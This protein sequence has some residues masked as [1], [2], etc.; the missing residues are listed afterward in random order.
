M[1]TDAFNVNLASCGDGA[2]VL[3]FKIATQ[4]DGSHVPVYV[5][6]SMNVL[7]GKNLTISGAKPFVFI[8]LD[9]IVISGTSGPSVAPE[10]TVRDLV[11]R[12]A[13]PRTACSVTRGAPMPA[14]DGARARCP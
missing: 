7:A 10:T 2:N 11:E 8:A 9:T 3:G 1:C 14:V 4:S 12:S 5:A 13:R 6:K